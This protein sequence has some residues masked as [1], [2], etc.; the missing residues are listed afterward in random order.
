M[1]NVLLRGT[2]VLIAAYNLVSTFFAAIFRIDEMREL[3]WILGTDIRIGFW[4][5]FALLLWRTPTPQGATYRRHLVTGIGM[6]L[7]WAFF[8]G[9]L[10]HQHLDHV[11]VR[12]GVPK[13]ELI[14]EY[15]YPA[16]F[17]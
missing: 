16:L 2:A 7:A 1:A 8:T 13:D 11:H 10:W 6:V 15:L 17:D 4:F 14:S 3:R 12:S 9:M 5:A